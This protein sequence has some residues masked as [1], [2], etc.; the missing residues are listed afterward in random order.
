[1]VVD[2]ELKF[3]D[4]H[5][6]LEVVE[7]IINI[8]DPIDNLTINEVKLSID[9]LH[10]LFCSDES[11]EI[12][13]QK[14]RIIFKDSENL[15]TRFVIFSQLLN[16]LKSRLDELPMPQDDKVNC[17]ELLSA[18][19]ESLFYSCES[20]T[21]LYMKMYVNN[22]SLSDSLPKLPMMSYFVPHLPDDAQDIQRLIRR[23]LKICRQRKYRKIN[24]ETT[25]FEPLF[26]ED[27]LFTH[28]FSRAC[29]MEVFV[30]DAIYP[31]STYPEYYMWLTS[32]SNNDVTAVKYLKNCRDDNLPTINVSRSMFSFKNG[33]YRADLDI[34]YP[35]I[36]DETWE[37][38]ICDMDKRFTSCNY[39]DKVFEYHTYNDCK[40]SMD[41]K[42]PYA[43]I[44]L[45]TQKFPFEVKCWFFAMMG[46]L[47]FDVGEKDN[48]EIFPF[49]KGLAGSGKSVLLKHICR[50]YA[51]SDV[52]TLMSKGQANFGVEHLIEKFLFVCYDLDKDMNLP[53]M[54]WNSMVSGETISI[55]R[56]FKIALDLAWSV[57]G[58]F[59]GNEFPPWIDQ[60]GN[61]SRRFL[62]F[63]F[64]I[65]VKRRD[66]KLGAKLFENIGAFLKKCIGCYLEKVEKYGDQGIWDEKV[67][68]TYFKK[69]RSLLQ[70]ETNPLVAFLSS[71]ECIIE[72]DAHISFSQFK[73]E[74]KL[75]CKTNQITAKKLTKDFI[76]PV[77][78]QMNIVYHRVVPGSTN[79]PIPELT[80]S[81]LM[82]VKR[83]A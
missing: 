67:L 8:T 14:N 73:S 46:R 17:E 69:T 31:F 42:T 66:P 15:K 74:Y 33:V 34:F 80:S 19:T 12:N 47:L 11:I 26:T 64:C 83:S 22:P 35:Y 5:T 45:D 78:S 40:S 39:I 23:Y 44:I 50:L 77:F 29:E 59:A 51:A 3:S 60:A 70:A 55:A 49:F 16:N 76:A 53:Q 37:H 30:Y 58:A 2:S 9:T 68:P 43:D 81:Y 6:I 32:K 28:Y 20:L 71:E 65:C 48:W 1:M 24:Q 57:P 38:S 7:S 13:Q 72:T 82:G 63:I 62:M 56:K 10:T 25:L 36:D 54:T 61:V 75:F 4:N 52:G 18:T 41:I 27:G 79:H 21:S